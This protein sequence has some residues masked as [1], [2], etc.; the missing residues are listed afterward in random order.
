L[1]FIQETRK[2]YMFSRI[3]KAMRSKCL[4]TTPAIVNN[5][6]YLNTI[7]FP[8]IATQYKFAV[9]TVALSNTRITI[10]LK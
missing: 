8:F 5:S 7:T 6:Q 10:P 4:K 2:S 9:D 1:N 3:F